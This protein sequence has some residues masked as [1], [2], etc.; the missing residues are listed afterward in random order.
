MKLLALPFLLF[1]FF[2]CKEKIISNEEFKV[3][4]TLKLLEDEKIK[5]YYLKGNKGK[6]NELDKQE[7]FVKGSKELQTIGFVLQQ[8]P[9]K[10]RIDLGEN[11]NETTVY[12]S[13]IVVS[14]KESTIKVD[15]KTIHRFF[16]HNVYAI[17]SE[18]G[19]ERRKVLLRYDPFI[20]STA[21]L[22]KKIELEF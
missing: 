9:Y 17:K 1:L 2:G 3:S 20:E 18:N 16:T 4:I 8:K 15:D 14:S 10:F 22:H 19:Y 13:S 11:K 7:L 6:Y 21:L 5:L 12:I